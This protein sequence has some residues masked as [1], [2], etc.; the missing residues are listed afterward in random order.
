MRELEFL[1]A[2]YPQ[3]RRQKRM[4][5]LQGW[6]TVVVGISLSTWMLL[7]GRNVARWQDDRNIVSNQLDQSR[8]RLRALNDQLAEKQKLET[9]Q[10]VMAKLGLHV[11]VSRLIARLDQI[12]PKE[13][14]LT[15]ADFN[16]VEQTKTENSGENKVQVT[17]RKLLVKISGVTPSDADWAGLL[18]KL[19]SVPFFDDVRLVGAKEKVDDGHLMREFQVSFL[20]DLG[21]GG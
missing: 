10:R 11:E 21:S 1:P 7:A 8:A 4:V 16:V 3:L 17:A 12:M 20:V 6:A 2:W 18:A 19:S 9:Q 5:V 13:M 15:E 14:A